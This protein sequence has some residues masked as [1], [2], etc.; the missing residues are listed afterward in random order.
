MCEV[1]CY[2]NITSPRAKITHTVDVLATFSYFI[3]H[4][5]DLMKQKFQ[6]KYMM[7]RSRSS[8]FDLVTR[9][10]KHNNYSCPEVTT[11]DTNI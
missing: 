9:F 5:D 3:G 4:N 6:N 1:N 7:K 10:A 2:C 8:S 11:M